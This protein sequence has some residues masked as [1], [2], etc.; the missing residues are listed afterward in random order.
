[1]NSEFILHLDEIAA[2]YHLSNNVEDKYIEAI[3]QRYA[4]GLIKQ[5]I[6]P[7][8]KVIELGYGDGITCQELSTF[9]NDYTVLEG[10]Q[11]LVDQAK[12]LHPTINVIKTLF[13]DYIPNNKIDV[14]LALHVFE[15]V[16]NPISLMLK[17]RDWLKPGG[18]MI[19]IVP[20]SQSYH[21]LLALQAGYIKELNEL[22]KRDHVVGHLRVYNLKELCDE[23]IDANFHV[24]S[25]HG[26]FF[27]PFANSQLMG[28]PVDL[29]EAMNLFSAKIPPENAAN[30]MVVAKK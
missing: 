10:S 2:D 30:I 5:Q 22:S 3:C 9:V 12:G 13:E 6:R 19:V 20:N 23:L 11:L 26:L 15:H 16:E 8:D 29:L 28:L 17:F 18:K 14:L 4:C 21:R 7:Y 25:V 24:N 1:M 27:K